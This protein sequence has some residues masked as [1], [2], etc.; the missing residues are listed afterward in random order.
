MRRTVR[1]LQPAA[2]MDRWTM[3]LTAR[4]AEARRLV[5][6]RDSVRDAAAAARVALQESTR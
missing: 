2:R 1:G 6:A 4:Y 5:D 3:A